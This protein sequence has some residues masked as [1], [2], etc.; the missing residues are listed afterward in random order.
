[1]SAKMLFA[2]ICADKQQAKKVVLNEFGFVHFFAHIRENPI[3]AKGFFLGQQNMP[4]LPSAPQKAIGAY[5]F[6]GN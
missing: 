4:A 6:A 5:R 1:M 2:E 3:C